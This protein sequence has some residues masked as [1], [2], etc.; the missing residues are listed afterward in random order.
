[1]R[2]RT[3]PP[4]AAATDEEKSAAKATT[5]KS[6]LDPFRNLSGRGL[7]EIRDPFPLSVLHLQLPINNLELIEE[8]DGKFEVNVSWANTFAV[9]DTVVVDAETYRLE[10]S[11]WYAVRSDFYIGAGIPILARGGG[12]LD[13]LVAGF[14][15]A[16][17][18]TPGGRDQRPNNDFEISIQDGNQKR[19]LDSGVGVGDF[20]LKGH[21]NVTSG[22]A[23][24]PAVSLDGLVSLPTS[25]AGFGSSGVD[26]G[27]ALAS[28]K[29]LLNFCHL[30]AVLGLT[31]LTDPKTE[32]LSYQKVG[33]QGVV[34]I[35]FSFTKRFSL[36]L[37]AMSF[38]PLLE[39][40]SPLDKVRNY[41]AGGVKWEFAEGCEL[42][43]SILENISP[44][45]NSA[46]VAFNAGFAF[47]F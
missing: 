16:F 26:L 5:L 30:Y 9:S 7:L 4:Q 24:L 45:T 34:G 20:F 40:P 32:G 1:M 29:T 33:N 27:I 17:N 36:V 35:E 21:W 25:T 37:Q 14:H 12:I 44:F 15:K 22:D 28:Y 19:T 38:S 42:E 39:H 2:A 47:H 23:C 31:Y 46:D 11:G 10:L 18:L 6:A 8:S 43:L 41:L 3:E 13:P